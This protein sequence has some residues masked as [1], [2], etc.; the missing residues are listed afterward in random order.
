MADVP[1]DSLAQELVPV[2][3]KELAVTNPAT[4][5]VIDLA[6]DTIELGRKLK[7]LRA[8]ESEL[9]EFK[10][11]V[12]KAILAQMDR[13]ASWTV[14]SGAGKVTGTSPGKVDYDPEM[15]YQALKELLEEDRITKEAAD[16]A[17]GVKVE[18]AVKKAGVNKLI[19]LGGDIKE[20]VERC[21]IPPKQ[22]RSVTVSLPD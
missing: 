8:L 5:E 2:E 1:S 13:N 21:K 22:G 7:E 16:A 12:Q 15:L 17:L 19:A 20:K 11:L 9:R 10:A 6:A 4:G 18:K 14:N 3:G